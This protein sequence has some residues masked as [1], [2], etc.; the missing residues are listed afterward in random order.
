MR[1]SNDSEVLRQ[2]AYQSQYTLGS[3]MGDLTGLGALY[4]LGA[5][6][7]HI[8]RLKTMSVAT[9]SFDDFNSLVNEYLSSAKYSL[10]SKIAYLSGL[11]LTAIGFAMEDN[12][13]RTAGLVSTFV[14]GTGFFTRAGFNSATQTQEDFRLTTT[15]TTLLKEKTV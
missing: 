6:C 5:D 3:A 15:G 13:L 11:A 1:L 7:A 12:I 8:N 10:A 4:S 14:V 2:I 9:K